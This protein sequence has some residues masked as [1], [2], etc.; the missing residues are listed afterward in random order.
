MIVI[1]YNVKP[2][3]ICIFNVTNKLSILNFSYRTVTGVNVPRF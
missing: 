1:F 3:V 2:Y